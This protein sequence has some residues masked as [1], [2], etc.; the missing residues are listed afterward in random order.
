[1]PSFDIT[2]KANMENIKNAVDVSMRMI[3]NRYDFKG[4][5][6]KVELNESEM[7]IEINADSEFQ[8]DQIKDILFPALE[9][10]EPDSSKR[11]SSENIETISGN[12]LKQQLI[13]R[14]GISMELSKEIIKT[15]KD[16]KIKVQ[17]SIQGDELRVKGAKRDVLQECIALVKSKHNEFPLNFGNFRD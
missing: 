12:K 6:A 16:S 7:K 5:S 4:T 1:M 3:I 2:S 8:I 14:S 10:K 15:V 13:I 9:K 11:M 17:C